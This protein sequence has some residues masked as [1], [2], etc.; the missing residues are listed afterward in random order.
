L[1]AYTCVYVCTEGKMETV[2]SFSFAFAFL[3]SLSITLILH[4]THHAMGKMG[5]IEVKQHEDKKKRKKTKLLLDYLDRD[6]QIYLCMHQ[7][8]FEEATKK[9]EN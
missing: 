5:K 6:E 8:K 2:D 4:C 9:R 7:H 3:L 1:Y